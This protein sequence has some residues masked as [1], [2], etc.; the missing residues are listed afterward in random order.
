MDPGFETPNVGTGTFNSFQY[1]PSNSPWTFSTGAGV[2]GNGGG[3]TDG[4]PDAPDGTQ[5]AFLQGP[6][7][8]SQ[9]VSLAAGTYSLSFS[10]AQRG[11][12]NYSTQT[13][14]VQVDG[15]VVGTFTPASA[16]Y[17]AYNTAS[18]TVTAG[19]HTITFVGTDPDGADKDN[20]ALIDQVLLFG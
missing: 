16:S 20:T 19:A 7:S 4:N 8:V 11:D 2:A 14:Q 17:S 15:T 5:V 10:A 18:F 12:G 3:F 13:I 1:H 9:A 6:S